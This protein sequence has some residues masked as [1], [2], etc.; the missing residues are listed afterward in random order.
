MDRISFDS[1]ISPSG[2]IQP[3]Y[4]RNQIRASS[5][6]TVETKKAEAYDFKRGEK[7]SSEQERFV[8]DIFNGFAEN[9]MIHLGA[10]LQTKAQLNLG[11]IRQKNYHSFLSSL[12]DPSAIFVFKIDATTKGIMCMEMPLGFALIDKLMGG[13]GTAIDEVRKFTELEKSIIMMPINNMLTAYTEAWKDVRKVESV[14]L[15]MDFNPMS[16]HIAIPS[17]VMVDI[18]FEATFAQTSGMV[19]V[20]IPF[21]YLKEVLPKIS[22]DKF[23][24]TRSITGDKNQIAPTNI[25]TGV[26]AAK[27]PVV[28]ELGKAELMFQDLLDLEVGDCIK[29]D[30]VVTDPMKLKVNNRTKFLG[31]PGIKDNKMSIQITKVLA[32]GD[33]D[34]EQ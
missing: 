10:L 4:M 26:E 32:E 5:R 9:V 14:F 33:E 15:S 27:I 34:D 19:D 3:Q 8:R 28:V 6:P 20:C 23:L 11:S 16:V 22:F 13:K 7:L 30:T 1:N 25:I 12:N 29:L 17:E 21:K 31:R 2:N 24:I 18:T